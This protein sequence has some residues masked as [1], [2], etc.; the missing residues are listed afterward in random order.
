MLE[1]KEV[2]AWTKCLPKLIGSHLVKG[3][4][5]EEE[6]IS[7]PTWQAAGSAQPAATRQLKEVVFGLS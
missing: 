1:R 4:M 6:Q 3:R 7:K 2:E 5:E